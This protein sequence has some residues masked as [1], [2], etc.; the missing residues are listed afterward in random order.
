MSALAGL[1]PET[2]LRLAP[3][4]EAAFPDGSMTASGLRR[5]RDAGRLETWF[6]AGKEYTSLAAIEEMVRKCRARPR[7]HASGSNRRSSTGTAPSSTDQSG[8]SGTEAEKL[9]LAAAL[10]RCQEPKKPSSDTLSK[11]TILLLP[12]RP[13]QKI[14]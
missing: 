12:Q 2:P 14:R 1:A 9:A 6:V 10:M 3:A 8:S 11:S 5:E 13:N 7:D 4:A